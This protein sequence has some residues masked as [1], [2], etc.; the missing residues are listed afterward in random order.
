MKKSLL[1]TTLICSMFAACSDDVDDNRGDDN[2]FQKTLITDQ[3]QLSQRLFVNTDFSTRSVTRA[4]LD[5]DAPEIPGDAI[6]LSEA[7]NAYFAS[8]GNQWWHPERANVYLPLQ[9]GM[10]YYIPE[11]VTFTDRLN[12][13]EADNVSIYVEGTWTVANVQG[14]PSMNVYVLPKGTLNWGL[15]AWQDGQLNIG[16]GKS[17]VVK[18]WGTINLFYDG[19]VSKITSVQVKANSKLYLFPRDTDE[20]YVAKTASD[21]GGTLFVETG[22]F[23]YSNRP[24]TLA[25][26]FNTSN[27]GDMTFANTFL[28]LGDAY[29]NSGSTCIFGKCST[30]KGSMNLSGGNTKIYVEEEL[31]AENLYID[32][33]KLYLKDAIVNV[34]NTTTMYAA[35]NEGRI[36]G[37]NLEYRSVLNTGKLVLNAYQPTNP[38]ITTL[39]GNLDVLAE[40]I[41]GGGA[42][43]GAEELAVAQINDGVLFNPAKY[44]LPATEC[45]AQVGKKDEDPNL[46]LVEIIGILPPPGE[47]PFSATGFAFNEDQSLLYLGWHSNQKFES[48]EWGGY[49]DVIK[50]DAYNPQGTLFEQTWRSQ[51]MKFNHTLY[52]NGMI[53][54]A[55]T[56]SKVG[57]ALFELPVNANGMFD[58]DI[59][60]T[61]TRVNLNGESAN[62]VELVGNNLVTISGWSQGAINVFPSASRD[63]KPA[64]TYFE[65]EYQGKYVYLYNN[66]LVTL[67]DSEN[68]IVEVYDVQSDVNTALS[69]SPILTFNAGAL[70][71]HDGKNVCICDD[72]YIYVC[73]GNN[74]LAVFD[75]TGKQVAVTT[76]SANGVDVDDEF[77]Y[78][79]SGNGVNIF[80]KS[81]IKANDLVTLSPIANFKITEA[82]TI[83]NHGSSLIGQS[84]NYI[85]KGADG[86]LYVAYG[87]YGLRIYE[88]VKK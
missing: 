20:L 74:K 58:N 69:G 70:N 12:M 21:Q 19:M 59:E 86:R 31:S 65:G 17:Q 84:S 68:G 62:C 4:A 76:T 1:F 45:R 26:D 71:P 46:E 39:C 2:E 44:Y 35:G 32:G 81:D 83:Q 54:A 47:H 7:Y 53:Y 14:N 77:I 63:K 5:E 10:T 80:N 29:I 61:Y 67:H 87:I 42:T 50:V 43:V 34:N 56:S 11:G 24:V 60:K 22:S 40:E 78:L 75:F 64:N 9:S 66:R 37:E 52:N 30:I 51:E 38:Q 82:T 13:N 55:G 41:N 48:T 79:A 49:M 16:D 57:A 33:C 36:V 27:G 28:C 8:Q 15:Y 85:K 18:C 25:G 72:N 23:F 3:S 88:V 6:N 73:R